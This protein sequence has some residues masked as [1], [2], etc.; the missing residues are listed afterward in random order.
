[1]TFTTMT[2]GDLCVSPFNCR[3]N[4]VDANAVEG[5][6]ESLL[7]RGQLYPLVVHP[8]PVE[9]KKKP[10]WGAIAG[11]RRY[12]AF[13]LLIDDGRLPATHPIEVIVRDAMD[14]AE[15][16]E[17]SLAENLVRVELRPYEVFTAVARA[18]ERGRSLKDIAET[19]GQSVHTIR[20]WC[21]LGNLDPEILTALEE[22]R[23]SQEHAKAFAATADR[24]LQHHAFEQFMQ[25]PVFE[26][27]QSASINLIRRLLKVGD[28][29]QLKH[30]NFVGDA[31]YR[32]AG[33][34]FEL[35]LWA[36]EAEMRG[37]VENEGLLLELSDAKLAKAKDRLR[38]QAGR[39]L[40]FSS[41][42][43]RDGHFA[44]LDLE[45]TAEWVPL[46][47]AVADRLA[48]L[49]AEM[50]ELAHS[51][52]KILEQPDSPERKAAIADIDVDYLPLE[53]EADAIDARR[54]LILPEGD[55][56]GTLMIEDDGALEIRW[57]WDSRQAKRAAQKRNGVAS[58]PIPLSAGPIVRPPSSIAIDDRA[59]PGARQT[60]DAAIR[61]GHGLSKEGVEIMRSVRQAMLRA[62]LIQEARS[63]LSGDLGSDLLVFCLARDRLTHP[64]R[65]SDRGMAGFAVRH[66]VQPPSV[67][68]H[69]NRTEAQRIWREAV[70]RLKAHRSMTEPDLVTAFDAFIGEDHAWK[71]EAAAIVAGCA[72]ERSADADGYRIDLHDY[73]ATQAGYDVPAKMRSLVEPTD[74]MVELM[75]R[76]HRLKW[77][78]LVTDEAT[79][80]RW[81]KL[82]ASALVAPLGKAL[83]KSKAWVHP[84]LWFRSTAP[85]LSAPAAAVSEEETA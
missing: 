25:R 31:V 10:V 19:N 70:E 47:P 42:Y 11:G 67:A 74:E 45:I 4:R 7:A 60:A 3:K 48:Y 43:P 18:H 83:R 81:E 50:D 65:A 79:Y 24:S 62:A 15:L 77:A 63:N 85:G 52:A 35:D 2:I 49:Q 16:V 55:I 66:D 32:E 40:R 36:D 29:E 46:E 8:L 82:K 61:D 58:P 1:M 41:D 76:E 72:L 44:L 20:Q 71:N 22:E 73:V 56:F 39:N 9:P 69:V 84:L 6:A 27:A 80:R 26:R 64:S 57:W 28:T 54:Q 78:K 21:R 38:L 33:G 30:L 17:M 5:M 68:D 75:P 34:R 53:R 37:R 23:I 59:S 13:K 51:A 12:R 14:E